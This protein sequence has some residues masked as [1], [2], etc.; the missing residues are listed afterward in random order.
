MVLQYEQKFK[1]TLK[2]DMP[3]HTQV[4]LRFQVCF[5]SRN[6]NLPISILGPNIDI[7]RC[8]KIQVVRPELTWTGPSP[9]LS[10][11]TPAE[12][13]SFMTY[14]GCVVRI[15]IY[16]NAQWYGVKFGYDVYVMEFNGTYTY[17]GKQVAGVEVA[18][19]HPEAVISPSSYVN[20]PNNYSWSGL[21]KYQVF[22]LSL[23]PLI[24][25]VIFAPSFL[26]SLFP[27]FPPNIQ[28]ENLYAFRACCS[29]NP[30]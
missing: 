8:I 18:E 24:S 10:G 28:V 14:P 19:P 3:A 27:A 7:V 20:I 26:P 4:G 1:L 15:P 9:D 12:G 2:R 29:P 13:T 30:N 23:A 16:A 6:S 17:S 11:L 22:R 5:R 25:P 21:L